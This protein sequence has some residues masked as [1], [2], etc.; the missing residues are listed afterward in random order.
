M[1]EKILIKGGVIVTMDRERRVIRDGAIAVEDGRIIKVGGADE[2][3]KE[4]KADE[5]IDAGKSIVLPGLICA[6]THL[7][8]IALRGA[9]LGI[10]PPSDFIQILQRIWWP[11]DERL[12]N[13]DAYAT[14]L[15]ASIEFLLSGTTC[16]A[17]TYSAPNSI[18]GSLNA[19]AKAVNEVGIRGILSFEATERRS[20]EEGRRG[21]KENERFLKRGEVGRTRGMICLHASFTVTDELIQEALELQKKTGARFTIHVSEGLI[22]VYH[23]LERYGKRTVER[24]NDI[25]ALSEKTIL[26]H[27]VHLNDHEIRILEE[28]GAWVAHN[29]MSNMLNAVG[30]ARVPDMLKSG[31]GVV[32]G[33]DGYI[34]DIFENMRAAF[35]IHRISRR[36]PNIIPALKV[37]E[38]AT[39]DAARAYG[40]DGEI[41]S[42]EAGKRADITVV[43]PSLASTP[44]TGDI[45]GWIIHGL[46]GGDVKTVIV[47]GEILLRNGRL[48]K[49]ELEKAE[50]KIQKTLERLWERFGETLPPS[51]EPLR[52]SE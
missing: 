11:V 34:F 10:E 4:F 31:V 9:K 2:V 1:A 23:N 7:Y 24:L 20:L 49:V 17:D 15:A 44:Y 35:L 38:M 48:V 51:I 36:D 8:G 40:L 21:L 37:L 32:L 3:R 47:D 16:F 26:A 29:P 30:V 19:I 46:R 27:C 39:I 28:S 45:Y 14:A 25:G 50:E 13:N 33:N 41:G 22:D 42:I 5:V 18:E 43:R 6:H 12:T 52:F